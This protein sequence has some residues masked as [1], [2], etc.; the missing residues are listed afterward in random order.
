M[1]P[2]DPFPPLFFF[3]FLPDE[4]NFNELCVIEREMVGSD[5]EGEGGECVWSYPV[6]LLLLLCV[7]FLAREVEGK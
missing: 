6:L 2:A 7:V 3:F 5:G 1:T 4:L